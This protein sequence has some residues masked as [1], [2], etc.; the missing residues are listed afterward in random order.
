MYNPSN[1]EAAH[2]KQIKSICMILLYITMV[3]VITTLYA[4]PPIKIPKAPDLDIKSFTGIMCQPGEDTRPDDLFY[5]FGSVMSYYWQTPGTPAVTVYCP[6][7]RDDVIGTD[8]IGVEVTVFD[9][10]TNSDV[11]CM[12]HA[13]DEAGGSVAN[14]TASTTGIPGFDTLGLSVDVS[15]AYGGYYFACDIPGFNSKLIS[16]RIYEHQDGYD[17]M[18]DYNN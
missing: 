3:S 13:V 18:T 17:D 2:M 10:D 9:G 15:A 4:A 6:I 11:S 8:G 16:Y 5:S 1:L 12:L 7:V 14:A